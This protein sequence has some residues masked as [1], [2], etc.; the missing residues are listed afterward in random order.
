[1]NF[2]NLEE[3]KKAS[4]YFRPSSLESGGSVRLRPMGDPVIGWEWWEDITKPDGSPGKRCSAIEGGTAA[5][6]DVPADYREDASFF[7]AFVAWNYDEKC[8]QLVRIT[9]AKIRKALRDNQL[10]DDP[11]DGWD[12]ILKRTGA[13]RDTNYTVIRRD[14]PVPEEALDEYGQLG[15]DLTQVFEENG[16]VFTNDTLSSDRI[17]F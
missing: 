8:V 10:P 14:G 7:W 12:F 6:K 4:R 5:R 17:P 1:M 2:N 3:G 15:P 13:G 11:E 16:K 9:Q